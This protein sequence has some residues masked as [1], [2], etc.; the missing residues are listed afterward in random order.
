MR[1]PVILVLLFIAVG[2][3]D[4][5]KQLTVWDPFTKDTLIH[6]FRVPD[7][8]MGDCW[9]DTPIFGHTIQWSCKN[10]AKRNKE[11]GKIEIVKREGGS[12]NDGKVSYVCI[13]KW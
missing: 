5:C 2:F 3:A 9:F 13:S 8:A 11:T 4:T 6:Y 1:K 12:A 7:K 10:V